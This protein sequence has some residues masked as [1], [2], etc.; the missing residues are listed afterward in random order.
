MSIDNLIQSFKDID[1]QLLKVLL[2]AIL[3]NVLL[4]I[5]IMNIGILIKYVFHRILRSK[6]YYKMYY[7]IFKK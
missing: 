4:G 3:I 7:S 5:I 1:Y 6:A 2:I